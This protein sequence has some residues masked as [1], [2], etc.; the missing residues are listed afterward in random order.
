[1][2]E[3]E[4]RKR[5]NERRFLK[6]TIQA[7]ATICEIAEFCEQIEHPRRHGPPKHAV[8]AHLRAGEIGDEQGL[9][10]EWIWWKFAELVLP[11]PDLSAAAQL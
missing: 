5:I 8:A 11:E 9:C 10:V 7:A 1:M 4:I 6:T 2:V 3:T